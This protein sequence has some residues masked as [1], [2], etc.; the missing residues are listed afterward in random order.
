MIELP[1]TLATAVVCII[2]GIVSG[3]LSSAPIGPANLWLATAAIPP[4]K[5]FGNLVAYVAGIIT[6]DIAYAAIAFYGYFVYFDGTELGRWMGIVGG[7]GLV[8]LGAL[9]AWKLRSDH[10]NADAINQAGY[11][12]GTSRTKDFAIGAFICG[13]NPAFIMFWM[14]IAKEMSEYGITDLGTGDAIYVFVGIAL[15][16]VLWYSLFSAMVK[17]GLNY[18]SARFLRYVRISVALSLVALGVVAAA[19]FS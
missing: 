9:E 15:G 17:F 3:I 12:P 6:I 14:M 16:D 11:K 4:A 5:A 13:S 8:V 19:R 1:D 2:A 18:I 7:L 10:P